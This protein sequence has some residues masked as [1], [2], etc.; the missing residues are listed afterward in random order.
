MKNDIEKDDDAASPP[1]FPSPEDLLAAGYVRATFD[2][3]PD[4][5]GKI[6]SAG[7]PFPTHEEIVASGYVP[8]SRR[9]QRLV[10]RPRVAQMMWVDFPHDA[11]SPE[12]VNE[13]PGIIIR[14][15]KKLSHDTC[16]VI[17]V[18]SKPQKDS[19][20]FH[21]LSENPN[22]DGKRRGVEAHAICD[23]LYTVH[24]NRLRP[25]VDRGK[26]V[27]PK[28]KPADM[29]AIYSIVETVLGVSFRASQAETSAVPVSV[30]KEPTQVETDQVPT[31]GRKILKLQPH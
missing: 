10:S 19:T 20:H 25:L 7:H 15:A 17:P 16:I 18:S 1:F 5:A 31:S 2:K 12:F 26:P 30:V 11:Y 23:H 28:V 22:P 3:V 9:E 27:Y 6:T 14:T 8:L 4:V 21:K 13:H 29:Q 24:V